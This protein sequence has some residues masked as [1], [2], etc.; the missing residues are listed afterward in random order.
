MFE[1]EQLATNISENSE[2]LDRDTMTFVASCCSLVARLK[3]PLR[4][5]HIDFIARVLVGK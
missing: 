5:T 4:D 2:S 3:S 1:N